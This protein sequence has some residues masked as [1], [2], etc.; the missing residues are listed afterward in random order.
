[1]GVASLRRVLHAYAAFDQEL[2][3]CQRYTMV[4]TIHRFFATVLFYLNLLT[5]AHI[6]FETHTMNDCLHFLYIVYFMLLESFSALNSLNFLAGT[7]LM[8]L[9]E[10]EAFWTLVFLMQR[11]GSALRGLYLEGMAETQTFLKV[12]DFIHGLSKKEE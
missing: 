3:Y 1:M 7:L 11:E 5:Y 8:Y 9:T 12:Y 6:T 10:R 2:G 4:H